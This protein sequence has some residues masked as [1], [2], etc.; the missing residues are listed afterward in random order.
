MRLNLS[1]HNPERRLPAEYRRLFLSLLK[2]A[3]KHRQLV[4][5]MFTR[6]R[7]RPYTFSVYLGSPLQ[8][9]RVHRQFVTN[10]H[11]F[12]WFSTGDTVL[13]S[14]ILAGI[15]E[16]KNSPFVYSRNNHT[17]TLT[18]QSVRI[19]PEPAVFGNQ[20]TFRTLGIA[21][22][23]DPRENAE[24][25][26]RWFVLPD[27]PRFPEVFALRARERYRWILGVPYSGDFAVEVVNP[28]KT[29]KV[30]HYNLLLKGFSGRIRVQAH[31]E[32]LKFLYQYG[33]GVR[34][35]QGFGMVDVAGE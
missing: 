35:G 5:L 28:P 2:K 31:P 3:L 14:E 7:T 11:I 24:D 1:L 18:L 15:M 13:G 19:V 4:D 29:R 27:D 26:D 12:F 33:I 34:T 30:W 10:D 25:M 17:Y 22:L 6:K 21:V 32:M 20:V 16:M 23:T 9:D 8:F